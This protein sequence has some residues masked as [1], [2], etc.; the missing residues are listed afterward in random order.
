MPPNA[1]TLSSTCSNAQLIVLDLRHCPNTSYNSQCNYCGREIG[2]KF[3]KLSPL[4]HAV[5]S[6]FFSVMRILEAILLIPYLKPMRIGGY[7]E[8]DFL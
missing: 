5:S 7:G 8:G 6:L 3:N 2:S 1:C 4:P